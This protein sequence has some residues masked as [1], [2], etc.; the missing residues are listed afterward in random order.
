MLVPG[1]KVWASR[2]S[3]ELETSPCTAVYTAHNIPSGGLDFLVSL[4]RGIG[5]AAAGSF[6]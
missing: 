4:P 6:H 1:V 5:L 3:W 2:N